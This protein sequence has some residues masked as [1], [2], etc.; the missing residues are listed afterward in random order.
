MQHLKAL[1]ESR[2]WWT[3][4]PDDEV[5]TSDIGEGP[6]RLQATRAEDGSYLM[7]Y[8]PDGAPFEADLSVLAGDEARTWWFDP[9][10]GEA[11]DAGTV[12]ATGTSFTPPSQDDWVLVADDAS[13]GF[14]APGSAPLSGD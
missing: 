4:V 8:S 5:V 1:M 14:E 3:G 10:T 2:P 6:S 9:R 7:V 11:T 12:P 13:R